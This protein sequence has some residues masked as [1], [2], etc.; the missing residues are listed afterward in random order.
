MEYNTQR[1]HL[2]ITDYGRNVCKLIDYAKT[3]ADRD[4]R[5]QMAHLIVEV[6]S[7]VN[8]KVKERTDYRHTLWDHL[9]EMSRY[10]LD[11]DSPYPI[12]H[13]EDE[14]LIMPEGEEKSLL[15]QQIAHTMKRQYLQWNRDS[16][17]DQLIVE[18]LTELS[19]GRIKLPEGFQF[20]DS[21]LYIDATGQTIRNNGNSIQTGNPVIFR[22]LVQG[23]KDVVTVVGYP[24]YFAYSIAGVDAT[25]ATTTYTAT[26]A[27]VAQGYVE[28]VNKGQ[29]LISISVTQNEDEG[30]EDPP[31]RG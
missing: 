3:I 9:M 11:V 24:G 8:P 18:Q 31:R 29:Y 19:E 16:V 5:T 6:M 30:G 10:E 22:V 2:K 25:E 21:K 28:I 4:E 13:E 26:A 27:D 20:H 7:Q 1:E 12:T 17:D 14:K 23:K 15:S